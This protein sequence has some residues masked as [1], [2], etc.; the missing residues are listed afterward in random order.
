LESHRV[1][2]DDARVVR[3]ARPSFIVFA[4]VMVPWTVY[5]AGTL[6]ASSL[7][8]RTWRGPAST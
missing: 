5:I 1:L 6:P 3:W 2:V 8:I 4:V 7:R